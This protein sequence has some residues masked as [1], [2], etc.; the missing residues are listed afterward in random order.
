[1]LALVQ[2]FLMYIFFKSYYFFLRY[3]KKPQANSIKDETA[4]LMQKILVTSLI[5]YVVAIMFLMFSQLPH[6]V[7]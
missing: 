5:I 4:Y 7:W 2:P 6:D 1:M 3:A